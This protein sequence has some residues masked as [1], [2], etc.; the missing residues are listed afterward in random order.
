MLEGIISAFH[1]A[2]NADACL[3]RDPL[4]HCMDY[5]HAAFASLEAGGFKIVWKGAQADHRDWRECGLRVVPS[6]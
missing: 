6:D 3:S 1:T 4:N 5:A 2:E